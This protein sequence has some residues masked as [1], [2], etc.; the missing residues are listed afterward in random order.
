MHKYKRR[1]EQLEDE[2]CCIELIKKR[3]IF[4][5]P[6]FAF[7]LLF[8]YPMGIKDLWEVIEPSGKQ[9]TLEEI[10]SDRAQRSDKHQLRIAIDVALWS[11]Q[12]CSSKGGR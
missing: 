6:S 8:L 12:A 1:W 11:F 7:S 3:S 9:Y 2:S 10:A 5:S 4:P